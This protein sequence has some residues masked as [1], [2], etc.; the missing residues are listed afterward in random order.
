MGKHVA[1]SLHEGEPGALGTR[2]DELCSWGI[3]LLWSLLQPNA[4]SENEV[5]SDLLT[6]TVL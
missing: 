2:T 3:F 6:E 1:I 5:R 4:L